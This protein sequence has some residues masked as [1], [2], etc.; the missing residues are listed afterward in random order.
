MFG[1]GKVTKPDTI[2]FHIIPAIYANN[3]SGFHVSSQDE[4]YEC[5]IFYPKSKDYSI[6]SN[7]NENY[8][9]FP[10][11]ENVEEIPSVPINEKSFKNKELLGVVLFHI[12]LKYPNLNIYRSNELEKI[13]FKDVSRII[14][15]K[16]KEYMISHKCRSDLNVLKQNN[17]TDFFMQSFDGGIFYDFVIHHPRY[18]TF[19]R[20]IKPQ[21]SEGTTRAIA[22]LV[23]DAAQGIKNK[24]KEWLLKE[25]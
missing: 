21:D 4:G 10:N 1:F 24:H 12:K 13:T 5:S 17:V 14:I 8:L 11:I 7:A 23:K 18:G 6:I 16:E 19:N 22:A 20:M 9:E 3:H 2:E 15:T 25:R